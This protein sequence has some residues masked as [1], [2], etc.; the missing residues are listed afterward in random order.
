M[1]TKEHSGGLDAHSRPIKATVLETKLAS[2]SNPFDIQSNREDLG[3][4]SSAQDIAAGQGHATV[5]LDLTECDR[6]RINVPGSIQPHGLLL[7]ADPETLA[8]VAGAGD[9]EGRLNAHWFGQPLGGLICQDMGSL[10]P[11]SETAGS[12]AV[13]VR[14]I[15][16]NFD[17]SLHRA[18][19]LVVAELEPAAN[20]L[21]QS[22]TT[23][24]TL[25][26]VG[27]LFGRALTVT[28]LCEEAALAFREATGFDRVMIYRFL[29][30]E[31]GC[32]VAEA[33]AP[34]LHSFL[35]HHF[36][37]TDIPRQARALYIRNRVRVI[38]DVAYQPAPLR[39][40]FTDHVRVDM[41]DVALRSVSPIHIQYLK[42]MGVAASASVSIVKDGFLWGLVACHH[43]SPRTLTADIR[44]FCRALASSMS[45]H[46]R[47]KEE[48]E[49]YRERLRLRSAEDAVVAHHGRNGL[50]DRPD[51]ATRNDMRLMLGAE[52][53]AAV[54]E[55]RGGYDRRLPNP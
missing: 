48:A 2:T 20:V 33:K 18:D 31:A 45:R 44:L 32:V 14:G 23:L 22:A 25:D 51:A 55:S 6:E 42:N 40:A 1:N 15:S 37:S 17:L 9:I 35:N 30:N 34:Q 28:A 39:P 12:L 7:I 46:I 11:L 54:R 8:V 3:P 50:L 41:S 26:R 49:N 38:P 43:L 47:A 24:A 21:A 19:G 29:D 53:F 10:L 13:K 16:E 4:Q 27:S 52:G 5:A 36:P